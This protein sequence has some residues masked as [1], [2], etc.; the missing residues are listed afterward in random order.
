MEANFLHVDDHNVSLIFGVLSTREISYN[1]ASFSEYS[2]LS[3]GIQT[4]VKYKINTS[5]I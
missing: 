2:G 5:V 1:S 4:P 3:N